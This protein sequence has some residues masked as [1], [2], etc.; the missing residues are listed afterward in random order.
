MAARPTSAKR[1]PT[2]ARATP[3]PKGARIP[4]PELLLW[5]ARALVIGVLALFVASPVILAWADTQRTSATTQHGGLLFGGLLNAHSAPR[6]TTTDRQ[7]PPAERNG[8]APGI[9]SLALAVLSPR[10]V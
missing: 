4:Q 8:I 1:A 10:V 9:A 5:S 6:G 2:T 3:L 7:E